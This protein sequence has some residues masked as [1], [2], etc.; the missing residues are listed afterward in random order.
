[1]KFPFNFI[2]F[3]KTNIPSLLARPIVVGLRDI[4]LLDEVFSE[5]ESTR[6]I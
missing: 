6:K 2:I 4:K 1:M 3:L 5:L